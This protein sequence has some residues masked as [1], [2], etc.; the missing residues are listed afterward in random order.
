MAANITK[1]GMCRVTYGGIQ[2]LTQQEL[3]SRQPEKFKFM[4]PGHPSPGNYKLVDISPYK[5]HQ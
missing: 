5:V 1:D 2:G 3:V 4:R